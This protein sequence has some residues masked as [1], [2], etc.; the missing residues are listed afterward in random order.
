M[1]RNLK[2][3]C[4]TIFLFLMIL[5]CFCDNKRIESKTDITNP[6]SYDTVKKEDEEKEQ[7]QSTGNINGMSYTEAANR[8]NYGELPVYVEQNNIYYPLDTCRYD[9]S[10]DL[11]SA[12]EYGDYLFENEADIEKK[13][14]VLF[15][16]D[17]NNEHIQN[18]NTNDR[19]V[20][21]DKSEIPN[22]YLEKV[23]PESFRY[24]SEGF[25]RFTD[26][27]SK[28]KYGFPKKRYFI[29]WDTD[30]TGIFE[31]HDIYEIDGMSIN[32]FTNYKQYLY[33]DMDEIFGNTTHKTFLL[34]YDYPT[35][36]DVKYYDNYEETHKKIDVKDIA[37]VSR[38]DVIDIEYSEAD[39]GY[40][41]FYVPDLEP[42]MYRLYIKRSTSV[43]YN[44]RFIIN[45]NCQNS[46]YNSNDDT[47]ETE[48]TIQ[49]QEIIEEEAENEI[50]QSINAD[51]ILRSGKVNVDL[52]EEMFKS[53]NTEYNYDVARL[54][55]ALC[56]A[57]YDD[58]G[59]IKEG[60]YISEAYRSLGFSDE[61]IS[62]YS[63]PDSSL[64]VSSYIFDD[65]NLAFSIASKQIGE[66]TLLVITFRGSKSLGDWSKDLFGGFNNKIFLNTETW[67]GF[68]DYWDDYNIAITNY[69]ENHPELQVADDE[70][71]LVILVTGHSLGAAAANLTGKSLNE[72]YGV[73]NNLAKENIYV[74][75]FACPLV[76]KEIT[77]DDNIFNIININDIVPKVPIKYKR[78]G[79]TF[80]FDN[81]Y[82][83]ILK[84]HDCKNYLNAVVNANIVGEILQQEDTKFT[85]ASIWCPV[86]VE[87]EKKGEVIGKIV[88]N[89]VTV[90]EDSL[91]IEVEDNH[92]FIM[93]PDD[94]EYTINIDA[95]DNGQMSI[96][97][98]GY[99]G[100]NDYIK[101]FSDIDIKQGDRFV[102]DISNLENFDNTELKYKNNNKSVIIPEDTD[103]KT[104]G[105]QFV[106]IKNKSEKFFI[107]TII[108][109]SLVFIGAII[110]II[111]LLKRKKKK[112]SVYYLNVSDNKSKEIN[113][114]NNSNNINI[115]KSDHIIYCS[116]CGKEL[117]E[118][119]HFCPICGTENKLFNNNI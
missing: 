60:K 16:L 109:I 68:Y 8:K 75:T 101:T 103:D 70:G 37:F 47:L 7:T 39:E 111:I 53:D 72:G 36:V 104:S 55:V 76:S 38:N 118:K 52:N 87:I 84:N 66:K 110:I 49:E 24:V 5:I 26:D 105:E 86:D 18:V 83:S 108:T 54:A 89:E 15:I 34:D 82:L 113:I 85:Y 90:C 65:E 74:Y 114:A 107:I 44:M 80:Y 115:Y 25:F 48:E 4:K 35:T 95:T 2:L 12:G 63:Y 96:Y 81:N 117:T 93:L 6:V 33:V 50:V 98:M 20:I 100:E 62:L 58:K 99:D 22:I 106:E 32:D 116:E 61:N 57:S 11:I 10:S 43:E 31:F 40:R 92:K 88:N 28:I 56:E 67:G 119:Q 9:V 41:Y 27:E 45:V 112:N 91:C 77:V 46:S 21:F 79:R 14:Q 71:K 1:K 29:D 13:E 42:G 73:F 94:E 23:E 3:L 69:Y 19:I 78:Y 64:N 59:E 102:A 97:L 17:E 30:A 51:I